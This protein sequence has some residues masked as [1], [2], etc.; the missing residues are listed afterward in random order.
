MDD[1]LRSSDAPSL[2]PEGLRVEHREPSMHY[3]VEENVL[4]RLREHLREDL[5]GLLAEQAQEFQRELRAVRIVQRATREDLSHSHRR[6]DQHQESLK[7]HQESLKEMG[8]IL[9]RL[10]WAYRLCAWLWKALWRW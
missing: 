8:L 2:G 3:L 6:L 7:E 4:H 1:A 9:R 10:D 5:K